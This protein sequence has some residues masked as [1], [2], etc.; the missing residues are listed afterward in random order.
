[1]TV[2]FSVLIGAFA[3]GQAGPSMEALARGQGAATKIWAT[4]DRKSAIDPSSSHGK[5]LKEVKGDIELQDLVFR[6]PTR[7][8]SAIFK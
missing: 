2:F 3:F 6:Y 7:P 4:I 5:R 1:L 8:E